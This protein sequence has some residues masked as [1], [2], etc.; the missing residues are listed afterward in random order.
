MNNGEP[1][2]ACGSHQQPHCWEEAELTDDEG[3]FLQLLN[4]EWNVC[5]AKLKLCQR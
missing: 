5:R 4:P 1:A 3:L 2:Q